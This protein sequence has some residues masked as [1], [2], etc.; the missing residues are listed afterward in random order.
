MYTGVI[1]ESSPGWGQLWSFSWLTLQVSDVHWS[2]PRSTIIIFLVVT[3]DLI[4]E[5]FPGCHFRFHHI[6][7]GIVMSHFNL[8]VSSGF[9][10]FLVKFQPGQVLGKLFLV[11]HSGSCMIWSWPYRKW[12]IPSQFEALLF[13]DLKYARDEVFCMK[14]ITLIQRPWDPDMFVEQ[15]ILDGYN[16]YSECLVKRRRSDQL[17]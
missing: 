11:D 4:C 5:Q 13:D 6:I 10:C 17:V 12:K 9:I 16:T 1:F 14:K 7:Y 15:F 2:S 3:S 8:A